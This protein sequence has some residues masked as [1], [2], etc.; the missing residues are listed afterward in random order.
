[1]DVR[2]T[3][4]A[5]A[6]SRGASLA[7]LSRMIGRNPAYLQQ[8]VQRGS[9]KRLDEAA[10]ARLAAF[11]GID[12][13]ELGAPPREAGMVAVRRIDAHAAAGPGGLVEDDRVV[14]EERV[15]PRVA[16]RLGVAAGALTMI[17]A[18][19]QSMEPLIHDGDALFVDS[20]DRRLSSRPGLFVLRLDG[21]LLVKRVARIGF[22]LRITSDNPATPPIAP[23]RADRAEIIGRVVR[24]ARSLK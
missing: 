21:V 10:R 9:P 11:F 22:E 20:G 19:G 14:G 23:V 18:R 8:F 13:S 15:D 2:T 17:T 3:I 4:A 24:L 12:E 1:M 5:M 6:E 7:A 16:A